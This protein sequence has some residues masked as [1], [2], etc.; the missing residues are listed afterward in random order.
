MR[1]HSCSLSPA[2]PHD[3]ELGHTVTPL[4]HSGHLS[5][6]LR[7]QVLACPNGRIYFFCTVGAVADRE[8]GNRGVTGALE[9][10][11]QVKSRHYGRASP[12]P[13]PISPDGWDGS[14]W[15]LSRKPT[16][17]CFSSGEL[18]AA[19]CVCRPAAF[20]AMVEMQPWRSSHASPCRHLP[21]HLMA[22][23]DW[24]LSHSAPPRTHRNPHNPPLHG[25]HPSPR[26]GSFQ[27]WV[28]EGE[29]YLLRFTPVPLVPQP[30]EWQ[31]SGN[32]SWIPS[33]AL[34]LSCPPL[35]PFRQHVHLFFSCLVRRPRFS[36]L[37]AMTGHFCPECPGLVFSSRRS[38][39][40]S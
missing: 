11:L 9:L 20:P 12:L 32:L 27:L 23:L 24:P 14:C 13:R 34:P 40:F 29:R 22:A 39:F 37:P 7:Q 6:H 10:N 21:G 38:L 26:I 36:W 35:C 5:W 4:H 1:F 15:M 31:R 19:S 25:L 3:G 2:I 28:K 30:G 17:H 33:L 18:G 16:G 8:L